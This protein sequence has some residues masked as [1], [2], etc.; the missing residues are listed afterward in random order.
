[1][2]GWPDLRAKWE[3]PKEW[4]ENPAFQP[5]P[6]FFLWKNRVD[7]DY[8]VPDTASDRDTV[9]SLGMKYA[10]NLD[11]K[12]EIATMYASA[13][14]AFAPELEEAFLSCMKDENIHPQRIL[15]P[16]QA[17]E[18]RIVLNDHEK[19]GPDETLVVFGTALYIM[20]KKIHMI[21]DITHYD[22]LVA[23]CIHTFGSKLGVSEGVLSRLKFP[24][25]RDKAVGV[26]RVFRLSEKLKAKIITYLMSASKQE[27]NL[28]K[29]A[30]HLCEILSWSEITAF[31]SIKE[32]LHATN[33]P[34]L[35]SLE[36]IH[37][38]R[39][40]YYAMDKVNKCEYPEFYPYFC[41]GMQVAE[42][43]KLNEVRAL[44]SGKFVA[45]PKMGS[46]LVNRLHDIC[47]G[48]VM[49][50]SNETSKYNVSDGFVVL[51]NKHSK[52]ERI[53]M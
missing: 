52:R 24:L 9:F 27:R 18:R 41:S 48:L 11:K 44:S 29:L 23:N 4:K 26:N 6:R 50:S 35:R 46:P 45:K 40:F 7:A 49:D 16:S 2:K 12:E 43:L 47:H 17:N 13:M 15:I 38:V 39:S 1:M 3:I 53:I 51:S 20:F 33:S 5:S 8:F 42:T 32:V 31:A 19:Y 34:V 36:I 25:T 37:E 21:K 10:A 14:S 30:T 28:S 22:L